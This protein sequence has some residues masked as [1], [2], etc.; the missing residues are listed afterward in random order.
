MILYQKQRLA[1]ALAGIAF[2]SVLL[3]P[4]FGGAKPSLLRNPLS[5]AS[6]MKENAPNKVKA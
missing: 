1:V 5:I 3:A 2:A 6:A 4:N